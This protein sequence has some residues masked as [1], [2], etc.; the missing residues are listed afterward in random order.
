[1]GEKLAKKV[2]LIGWDAAD[3]KVI[4]PLLDAGSMPAL[5]SLVNQ[6]VMGNLATL[7]PPLSP[8][9]WTSIATGMHADKHG[10]LNFTEP[11][12]HR[13]GI[14][15]VMGT[16]R[17]VKAV[18]NILMQKGFKCHVV[19][20]WPSHPAEP[21]NG[22]TISNFYQRAHAP[23]DKPWPLPPGTVHPVEKME[24]F[25]KMRIHPAELTQAHLLP[26]VP[27]AA[28][29]N[30][31]KDHRL[32][33]L[34]RII[35]DCSTIHAATTW[36]QENETWDF[37]AVYYDAIDHFSHG[38]MQF[39]P[40]K[41]KNVP[42]NLYELYK[43]VVAGGYMYHDMM[44]A[45]LLQLA[46]DDVT[47]ILVSDHG[48]HSDHLRPKAI[49][50]EPAG[51]A[52]EHRPYGIFVMRGPYIKKDER[53]YGAR[54]LDVTPTILT[55]YGLPV[56][57]DMDGKCLVQVFE[58]SVPLHTIPSWESVDGECG[59]YPDHIIRDPYAEQEAMEQLI[60]LGYIEKPD[61]N[62]EKALKRTSNES[63]FFLARVHINKH[64][65]NQAL[66]ILESL[67]QEN[68]DQTRYAFQL[69][70]CYYVTGN[71]EK[72]REVSESILKQIKKETPQ[73]LLLRGSLAL[74]EGNYT[75]AL[76]YLKKAE[77]QAP[78]LPTLHQQ[79]G[80]T[81]LKMRHFPDAEQAFLK[82]LEIDPDSAIAY[83]GLSRV[84]LRMRRNEEAASAALH[85]IGLLYHY[86]SAHY[87]LGVAL[88]RL[89][90]Y[91]R[92]AEA[93]EVVLAMA[94]GLKRVHRILK[95]LYE[96]RLSQPEKANEHA[97]ILDMLRKQR[98]KGKGKTI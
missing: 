34:A 90:Q 57:E 68:P 13:G 37:L 62:M 25:D 52:W 21:L 69:A 51:P 23:I 2:L 14:R 7:D 8:M 59:R 12:P 53:I 97:Q 64:Q 47:V 54:L 38:F 41:M 46:G 29:V 33:A 61:E 76:E 77:D 19:G 75:T 63:Q 89:G 82:A 32:A 92:A 48:F 16:S 81:Y 44:L 70:K 88:V 24:I 55:L 1:M 11:A 3:W 22:I 28:K 91:E 10:I 73:L 95:R 31:D 71:L 86:P 66:P 6:G 96:R 98:N 78:R 85:A 65:F 50:K 49:P 79:I 17:K 36:I 80:L 40:P 74:A 60:A 94:P 93:F 35:A 56:G 58:T 72:C 18:W 39:H 43:H 26:F 45:R 15:P 30:Q 83:D 20:W 67:V 27:D 9:L 5:E 4:N 87:K 84:Y 42:R